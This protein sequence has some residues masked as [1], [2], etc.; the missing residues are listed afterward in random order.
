MNWIFKLIG[1]LLLFCAPAWG[2]GID[3]KS[4]GPAA[5][6][7]GWKA[8]ENKISIMS[9]EQRKNLLGLKKYGPKMPKGPVGA[10][11]AIKAVPSALDWRNNGG[12][13]VTSVKDQAS[14]GSCW[15]FSAVG[16]LES[17]VMIAKK[18]PG[19]GLDL[20]E[21]ILVSC[22][23]GNQGCNGGYMDLSADF[24]K[25][26][27]TGLESCYPYTATDGS[28][29]TA[30]SDSGAYKVASWGYAASVSPTVEA[31]KAALVTYGPLPT[32]FMVYSDFLYYSSGVY[33]YTSGQLEGG[34]AVLL[35]GY[36]DPGQYFICKNSWGSDFGEAGYFRISYSELNSRVLFGEETLWYT[37]GDSPTPPVPPVPPTPPTPGCNSAT[38]IPG[39]N[40][41]KSWF[42]K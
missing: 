15:A 42:G 28:C 36:D 33:K 39:A 27:G 1:L 6:K 24:L 20:S 10:F 7:S 3:L 31:L 8:K 12:N 34:H 9:A 30:C 37:V 16:G 5:E 38:G 17:A 19:A 13:F 32:T 2:A 26:T 4:L 22:S 41:I 18:T 21:Q 11:K 23:T 14:C 35:V 29:K 40:T 25:Y